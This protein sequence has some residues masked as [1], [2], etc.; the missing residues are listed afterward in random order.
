M[1]SISAKLFSTLYQTGSRHGIIHLEFRP[2][3]KLQTA[4]IIP[5]PRIVCVSSDFVV[6]LW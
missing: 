1:V 3:P 6:H 2:G 4:D 5:T